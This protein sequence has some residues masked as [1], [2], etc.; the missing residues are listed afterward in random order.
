MFLNAKY[1]P[2]GSEEIVKDLQILVPHRMRKLVRGWRGGWRDVK[3]VVEEK[4]GVVLRR[5]EGTSPQQI[6]MTGTREAV[7]KA[8]QW[9]NDY[10]RGA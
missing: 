4:T 3:D 8:R 6:L 10:I 7:W 5:V 9:I 2:P 1:S